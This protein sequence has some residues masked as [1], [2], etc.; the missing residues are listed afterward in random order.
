[1]SKLAALAAASLVL[2]ACRSTP[3]VA[4]DGFV[5]HSPF[6]AEAT[7]TWRA[8]VGRELEGVEA[9]LGV[10]AAAPIE[11]YL[12]A[13]DSPNVDLSAPLVRFEPVDVSNGDVT[14]HVVPPADGALGWTIGREI[15]VVVPREHDGLFAVSTDRALRHEFVH[16]L[17]PRVPAWYGEGLAH[18]VEDAVRTAAGLAPHPAPVQ[19]ELARGCARDF[20]VANLW[21]WDGSRRV[22]G[23]EESTYRLLARSFVR[24]GRE[25]HAATF[26][27]TADVAA[28]TPREL[29]SEWRAWLADWNLADRVAVGARDGDPAI[30][31]AAANALPIL[32]E[33]AGSVHAR[34]LGAA[35]EVDGRA[36]S[37]A[38]NLAA[39]DDVVVAE[40]AARYLVYFRAK[41]VAESDVHAL[42]NGTAPPWTRLVA[43]AVAKRRG[44]DADESEV[45]SLWDA[46]SRDERT[47]FAWLRSFLT[48]DDQ[49]RSAGD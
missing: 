14:A 9:F 43:L 34:I 22:T 31:S 4:G 12:E 28:L 39:S 3:T 35:G 48:I 8:R 38:L 11:V 42:S 45:R 18:E 10:R 2:A 25:R 44:G 37:V 30:R 27:A 32:A 20:S 1:M 19:V 6:P 5:L 41:D 36:D 49:R 23:D 16:A 17:L 40:P 33:I 13:M 29:V 46:M 21:S 15:H 24:F 26:A 7:E 47:R